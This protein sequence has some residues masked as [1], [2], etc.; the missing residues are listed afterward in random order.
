MPE[1]K[2]TAEQ[3]SA[4]KGKLEDFRDASKKD[5]AKIMKDL[6]HELVGAQGRSEAPIEYKARPFIFYCFTWLIPGFQSIKEWFYNNGRR[7]TRKPKHTYVKN[8]TF[9][10]VL[11]HQRKDD[12]SEEVSSLSGAAPGTKEWM[13]KYQAGVQVVCNR[14]TDEE[15]AEYQKLAEDWNSEAPHAKVQQ[16]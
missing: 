6:H 4:L 5:R 12:I 15:V 9:K 14:L 13:A 3:L 8:W 16:K 11:A 2:F 1:T 10:K 7:R